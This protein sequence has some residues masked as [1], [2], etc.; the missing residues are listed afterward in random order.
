[1]EKALRPLLLISK[2]VLIVEP[3]FTIESPRFREPFEA[4]L[5][6]TLD[7]QSRVRPD[8][9]LELHLGMDR[10]DQYHDKHASLKAFLEPHVPDGM[11]VTVVG[12]DKDDLHDRYLVA[13]RFGISIGE[14]IGLPDARTN[15]PEDVLALVDATTAGKLMLQYCDQSKHKLSHGIRGT[16]RLTS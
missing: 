1:L 11:K 12:W 8:L 14:G 16:K 4:I 13:D 7:L 9:Q 15:R 10:L 3:N 5:M 2:K 6:A